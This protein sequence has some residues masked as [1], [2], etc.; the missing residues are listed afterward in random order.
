MALS[1]AH[2]SD[3]R[4]KELQRSCQAA[5]YTPS[6]P[7]RLDGDTLGIIVQLLAAQGFEDKEQWVTL[8]KILIQE[9]QG[10]FWNM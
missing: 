4:L 10:L 2:T 9:I 8:K 3:R 6:L 7:G 1:R 5:T